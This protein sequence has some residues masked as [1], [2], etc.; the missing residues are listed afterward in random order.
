LKIEEQLVIIALL[1]LY[2]SQIIF[3]Q[4]FLLVMK[5]CS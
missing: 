1:K 5:H 2:N 3:L 4:C